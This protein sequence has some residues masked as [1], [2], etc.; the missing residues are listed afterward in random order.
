MTR[1]SWLPDILSDA[2]LKVSVEPGWDTRGSAVLFSP[3]VIVDHGTAAKASRANPFPSR[4]VVT[5]G[6]S[7]LKGPL[8]NVLTSYGNRVHVV[9]SGQSN[10]AGAGGWPAYS[11]SAN[12]HTIGNEM[13]HD[14]LSPVP[15]ELKEA[16]ALVDG[17][18]CRHLKWSPERCIAHKEWAPRRKIDPSWDQDGHRARVRGVIGAL[19]HKALLANPPRGF[20]ASYN[21]RRQAGRDLL[22]RLYDRY[23]G[24]KPD[25]G[26]HAYWEDLIDLAAAKDAL[27]NDALDTNVN[28]IL[29][30]V[31]Q[32]LEKE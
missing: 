17:A 22:V 6:R 16:M 28:A 24:R 31:Q 9:A 20:M 11:A 4:R 5:A 32:G 13:E 27:A 14:N 15:T 7:D 30:V 21:T 25:D 2:G 12:R 10:N 18:I 29:L 23:A 3:R 26:G 1:L 19:D 8:C